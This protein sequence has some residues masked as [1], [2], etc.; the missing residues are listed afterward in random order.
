[1]HSMLFRT[2]WRCGFIVMAC[3]LLLLACQ[4]DK[5][6]LT[7]SPSLPATERIAPT[8]TNTVQPATPAPS[9]M[10]TTIPTEVAPTPVPVTPTPTMPAYYVPHP[11]LYQIVP[12]TR[13]YQRWRALQWENDETLKYLANIERDVETQCSTEYWAVHT[14]PNSTEIVTQ[15]SCIVATMDTIPEPDNIA[16]DV[17]MQQFSPDRSKLFVLTY[18]PDEETMLPRLGTHIPE[19]GSII[20]QGWLG[21]TDEDKLR[22]AFFTVEEFSYLWTPDSRYLIA[23]GDICYGCGDPPRSFC[24]TGLFS[25]DADTVTIHP[26]ELDYFTG[27]EGDIV[28]DITPTG[29]YVLYEPGILSSIDGS[30]KTRIC[31]EDEYA[32]SYTWSDDGQ[33]AYV[34]CG[35]EDK[36]DTLY[37][38]DVR[39]ETTQVLIDRDV[40]GFK[41]IE[42]KVSPNQKKLVFVWNTNNFYNL[43]SYGL[44]IIDFEKLP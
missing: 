7:P 27:C 10:M 39:N 1:M 21:R 33:Y 40:L 6:V 44:W 9:P 11:A 43:E 4:A 30:Q 34:A 36:S 16:D 42:M 2:M 37:R 28:Y 26:I 3:T 20:L 17:V 19:E 41:A 14:L 5:N 32:R 18:A 13:E 24:A 8:T 22:S 12:A 15:T 31:D 29:D 35:S 23:V 38:Y 25:I